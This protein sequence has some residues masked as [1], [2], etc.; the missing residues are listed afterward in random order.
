[1]PKS[2]SN[3]NKKIKISSL[4]IYHSSINKNKNKIIIK[5]NSYDKEE[6]KKIPLYNLI[7]ASEQNKSYR[8]LDEDYFLDENINEK[9]ST[10][11]N[12]TLYHSLKLVGNNINNINMNFNQENQIKNIDGIKIIN[13]KSNK[14]M[15]KLLENKKE[16]EENDK[17]TITDYN[18][19]ILVEFKKDEINKKEINRTKKIFNSTGIY[20]NNR[21]IIKTNEKNKLTKTNK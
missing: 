7:P 11:T 19:N 21:K 5:T 3:E 18:N 1:L 12:P 9:N 14:S 8:K 13:D 4:P 20:N 6:S 17:E 2:N 10:R 15:K 16:I